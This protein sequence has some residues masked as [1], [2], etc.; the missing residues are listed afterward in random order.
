MPPNSCVRALKSN[1]PVCIQAPTSTP[2][3]APTANP[4][5]APPTAVPTFSPT[6]APTAYPF[7]RN[8][9]V[10]YLVNSTTVNDMW[11][12]WESRVNAS[13]AVFD[14]SPTTFVS[15]MTD[16][17]DPIPDNLDDYEAALMQR[18]ANNTNSASK[19][20]IKWDLGIFNGMTFKQFI[21]NGF[22]MEVIRYTLYSNPSE[23]R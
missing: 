18:T 10:Y 12:Y 7:S 5:T 20:G 4:T 8:Q 2:T 14:L 11:S 17:T 13:Q 1:T 16:Y 19:I 6:Q 22:D 3:S 23:R 21:E 9:A 15:V